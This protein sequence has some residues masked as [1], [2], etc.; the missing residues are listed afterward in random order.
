MTHFL[1]SIHASAHTVDLPSWRIVIRQ[2]ARHF[3]ENILAPLA[4]F[5]AVLALVDLRGAF[6]GALSW[7]YAAIA[8]RV[9]R[10]QPVPAL[11]LLSAVLLTARSA[12]G[13]ATGSAFLYFL[14]PS[15]SNFVIGALFL[16][17]VPV[18]HPL[19]A[20][21]ARDFCT[22][23]PGLVG[24]DGLRRFFR[25]VSLLWALV[26]CVNGAVTVWMLVTIPIAQFLLVTTGSS[27]ATIVLAAGLSL[28]WFRRSLRGA[29][30][31]LRLGVTHAG[32]LP[33]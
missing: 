9:V 19:A 20:K 14:Q 23:P 21:L 29:G 24:H 15:L 33:G 3:L 18:G 28:W 26:F 22:F 1:S 27:T 25:Q 30:V 13:L 16:L 32:S 8:V 31:R 7:C 5:Y 4:V 17:S 12:V 10:R 6:I 11:L 2:A